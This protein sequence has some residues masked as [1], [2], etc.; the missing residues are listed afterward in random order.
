MKKEQIYQKNISG[1]VLIEFLIALPVFL[2]LFGISS[3]FFT[4]YKEKAI[5]REAARLGVMAT[6][7]VLDVDDTGLADG[8][9]LGELRNLAIAVAY[10]NIIGQGLD[11]DDYNYAVNFFWEDDTNAVDEIVR[12]NGLNATEVN[13]DAR[14]HWQFPGY[15]S[16]NQRRLYIDMTITTQR[17][18]I[19]GVARYLGLGALLA[20]DENAALPLQNSIVDDDARL[21]ALKLDNFSLGARAAGEEPDDSDVSE[22][23][24]GLDGGTEEDDEY[25]DDYEVGEYEDGEYE[26][27]D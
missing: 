15:N 20:C 10:N 4:V 5:I 21:T 8:A 1:S 3:T 6:Q 14:R 22:G 12:R 25:E 16:R 2:L 23:S 27:E 11:A 7:Y 17:G 24:A 18:L 9:Y 13:A 19:S 26:D